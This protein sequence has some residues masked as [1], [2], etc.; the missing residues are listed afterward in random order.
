MRLSMTPGRYDVAGVPLQLVVAQALVVPADRIIGL[1]SW[2]DTERYTIAAKAPDGA[3]ANGLP[4]MVANLL[5]DRFQL[6]THRETRELPVYNL[7]FAR[8]DK[9]FGPAFK[10]SSAECRATISA[11]LE[12][13]KRDGPVPAAAPPVQNGCPSALINPGIASF[14]GVPMALIATILTQSVGR[15]V[16]DRTG[17]A[18]YYDFDLKWTPQLGSGDVGPFGLP[19]G[20]GAQPPVADPDAPNLFTAVQE[21]LGLKLEAG[22]GPVE[23]VVIDRLE[24]PTLD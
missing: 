23:V 20:T 5:K 16:L 7:V 24:T 22:R 9:R 14:K 11:R 18:S 4:I 10:E 12:A 15:P 21:Q 8:N 17:L 3:P 13:V 1:P 6:V 19:P 2:I